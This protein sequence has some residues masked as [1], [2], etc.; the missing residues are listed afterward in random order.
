M[1]Y[2]IRNILSVS[3]LALLLGIGISFDARALVTL[4]E[5]A[6]NDDINKDIPDEFAMFNDDDDSKSA[7]APVLANKKSETTDEI[8]APEKI[9]PKTGVPATSDN[10]SAE[11]EPS[12]V[13][14]KTNVASAFND[15]D[16]EPAMDDGLFSQMSDIE[17]Q[18]ALLNLELRREK[19]KNEIEAIKNQRRQ[20][21]IQE[22]EK[23]EAQEKQKIEWEKAQEQKVLQEQQKLR[24]LDIEFEKLRQ[25]RI[26]NAYK[27]KYLEDVQKWIA[28]DADLYKQIE[29]TKKEN[30]KLLDDSKDKFLQL[31]NDIA[32]SNTK[33][34]NLISKHKQRVDD[35]NAQIGV[36]K[37]RIIAQEKELEASR[38]NPFEDVAS[39]D[40]GA[41][42]TEQSAETQVAPMPE[43]KLPNMYAVMEIR[44]QGGELI[45]KLVNQDGTSFYV[46]KGT[47]LQSGHTIDEITSTYVRADKGGVKDYLYFAAGGILPLE[48]PAS[49]LNNA[50]AAQA[51]DQEESSNFVSSV[52]IPGVGSAMMVR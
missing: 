25:E 1:F 5:E 23:K 50:L 41:E 51:E 49:S 18:T 45:A 3:A 13:A 21:L 17:K 20:A 35:L 31:K 4:S 33:A 36:L 7:P 37:S 40:S 47:A 19:I 27:N 32:A 2:K 12:F 9:I 6:A 34:A 44:G 28:H 16:D 52:G 10:V 26:L 43:L 42:K 48:Q 38:Q 8:F 30:Q 22:Q 39:A 11:K 14:P 46:K 15:I 24:E 29:D